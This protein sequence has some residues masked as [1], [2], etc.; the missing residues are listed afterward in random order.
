MT[1]TSDSVDTPERLLSGYTGRLS[2]ALGVGTFA[3]FLGQQVL[4][5]LLP[6][7]SRELSLTSSESGLTLTV[8]WATFALSQY[9]SG[10][11]SD[12]LSRRT[13]LVGGLALM[14]AG[15][16]I[17]AVVPSFPTLLL[18]LSLVGFGIGSYVVAMRA[19]LSDLYV[20]K[21]GVAFGINQSAT[22]VGGALAP[23]VA[24]VA[25]WFGVW[26]AA[27]LP[28]VVVLAGVLLSIH[29]W[30]RERYRVST[31]DFQVLRT[32]GRIL[33]TRQLRWTTVV[34]ILQVFAF[35]AISGFLPTY[36][37]VDKGFSETLASAG[38]AVL[39]VVGIFT[40]PIAG[41]ISDRIP[42]Q[43]IAGG[44]LVL[45]V[46]GLVVVTVGSSTVV[47]LGGIVCM[48]VGIMSY[49]PVVQ[50]YVMDLFPDNQMGNDFGAFRTVYIG[51]GSLGPT[52]VGAV[53]GWASF[54]VA[55]A[56]LVPCLLLGA[57]I[58]IV[59]LRPD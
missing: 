5:P 8:M 2:I 43:S 37:Q 44:A 50:A 42:R 18:G 27:F 33:E 16:A 45:G 47:V 58:T 11:Y 6:R 36:L 3:S 38:F 17:V 26:E 52:Y 1:G 35:Q 34:Y 41:S 20:R 40:T 15:F 28:V 57:V 24:I 54:D 53:S 39:F 46:V 29:L 19:L 23:A 13:V 48:A 12:E 25:L 32:G 4:P 31:V 14:I 7:I 30:S 22:M 10:R 55:F 56:G 59:L 21:R 51:V 9:P 49:P